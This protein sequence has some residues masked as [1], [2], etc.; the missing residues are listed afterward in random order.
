M[1]EAEYEE[2]K[3]W[4]SLSTVNRSIRRSSVMHQES[5]KK[6]HHKEEEEEYFDGDIEEQQSA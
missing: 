3:N 1:K 4:D 2:Y 5:H 6:S